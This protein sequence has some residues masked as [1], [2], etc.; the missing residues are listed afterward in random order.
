MTGELLVVPR[1]ERRGFHDDDDDDDE[2]DE[3]N[4]KCNEVDVVVYGIRR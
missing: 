1:Q 4:D 2:E 3:D